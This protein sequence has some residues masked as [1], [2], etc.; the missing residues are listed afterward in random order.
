MFCAENG[1]GS[2]DADDWCIRDN[3]SVDCH[4]EL[5]SGVSLICDAAGETKSHSWWGMRRRGGINGRFEYCRD[6]K[7]SIQKNI[8]TV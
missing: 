3:E 2:E 8:K 4:G 1:A 5:S 7:T 6:M